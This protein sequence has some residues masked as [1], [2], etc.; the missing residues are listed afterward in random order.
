MPYA[1]IVGWGMHVPERIVTNDEFVGM[2]LDTSNEW[3]STRTGIQQRHLVDKDEPVSE[4]AV[5]SAQQALHI[6]DAHPRNIDLVVLA[7]STPDQVMPSTAS[8]VQ[9]R[10]GAINAGAFDLNAACSGFVYALATGASQ[11]EAGRAENV[12]VIGAD[13]LSIFLNW[14]D[15]STCVLFG[16]GAGAV[17]LRASEEPG[18]LA[19]TMGSDGSGA[20]LLQ[21]AGGGSR[22]R[23]NGHYGSNGAGSNGAYLTMNGPQ[24]FR[25][26]TQMLGKAARR[27]LDESELTPEQV[28]LFI[29]HQAN[30]RIIES[31]A[32]RLGL[33]EEKV[34]SNVAIYGNTSAAS[35]PIALCEAISAERVHVGDNILLSSFGS[36]LSWAALA[37]RWGVPIP[38]SV[39]RWTP[40]RL[41]LETRI[42][43]MRTAIKKR[44]RAVRA[45]VD[46]RIRG[47]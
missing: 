47:D 18:I 13:E 25:F 27:V 3:I 40:I 36:G 26:A 37:L 7:T 38:E 41:Q 46:E 45:A 39:P 15:R 43:R 44:E 2:G 29:P 23:T 12:M 22:A 4:L 42:A 14:K 5:K 31:A 8:I 16:D 32:K 20:G 6:A 10:L 17:L 24:I 30:H 35:I 28:D 1:Q 34:F 19:S 21:I 33:P 9:H 11:I